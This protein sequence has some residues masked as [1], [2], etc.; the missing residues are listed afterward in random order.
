MQ[1][2]CG[3]SLDLY[4]DVVDGFAC[5]ADAQGDLDLFVTTGLT[6]VDAL[7]LTRVNIAS[8]IASSMLSLASIATEPGEA[9][10]GVVRSGE[11]W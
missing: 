7:D 5:V 2:L 9:W 6:H 3:L 8:P 10:W 1:R 4:E 11:E